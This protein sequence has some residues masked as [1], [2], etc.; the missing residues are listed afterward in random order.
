MAFNILPTGMSFQRL[1]QFPLD[2][3][4]IHNTL[5]EAMDYAKNNPTAYPGQILYVADA[6]SQEEIAANVEPSESLYMVT[7][8]GEL[9]LVVSKK[10]L[11]MNEMVEEVE[12]KVAE[13]QGNLDGA[14][15]EIN[16]AMDEMQKIADEVH[17][18]LDEAMQKQAEE[19]QAKLEEMQKVADEVHAELNENREQLKQDLQEQIAN[20]HEAMRKEAEE[21]HAEIE[22]A[23]ADMQ[24]EA[25]AKH[26][27]MQKAAE[28]K[29]AEMEAKMEA[30]HKAMKEESD[31]KHAE[32]EQVIAD[33]KAESEAKHVEMEEEAKAKHEEM[34]AEADAEHKAVRELIDIQKPFM[35]D[36]AA[37]PTSKF[38]FACGNPITVEPNKGQKYDVEKPE[39][40]V[41][42]VYRWAEG[43]EAIVVE[44]EEAAKV[45]VVGGHGH[46][47]V[48]VKR[49][50]P[51]TNILARDV[52]IKGIVG[53]SYFEG[54]VGH[55]NI[56]AENCE[57]VSVMGAGWCGASIDGQWTRMNIVDDINMKLT[58]CKVS[59]TLFGGAQGNGVA[60]DIHMELNNCQIGWLTAGGANGMTRNAE[61]VM[62]GGTVTV[63]QSTNR[64]VV[65]KAKLVL[66]DG[67]INSLYFG[68][69]TE[70]TTVDGI[71][72]DGHIELNGGVVKSFNFGT[73]NGI[74][75][76]AEDIKGS[77]RECV[78]NDGDVSMLEQSKHMFFGGDDKNV[79]CDN[80]DE[81]K[82]LE[83]KVRVDV[84]EVK[85]VVPVG[86]QR[87]VIAVPEEE[88]IEEI[89]YMG[90]GCVDYK[91][92]FEEE[93]IEGHKVMTYIFAVPCSAKMTFKI[94]LK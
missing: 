78:V 37:Y 75:M 12:N 7:A 32:I 11:D 41:A 5:A 34:K 24:A 90:Q 31:A 17:A 15:D 2:S 56:E 58:N 81:V 23:M 42:F 60:D 25:D 22:Q 46:D 77:I 53:G 79:P 88:E 71:I 57:F 48:K 64:G 8:S 16:N 66:N 87:V 94:I 63:A 67:V 19:N 26:E 70:D 83:G 61:V 65:H 50:I 52:K 14:V 39:D 76:V 47:K 29:H 20:E 54:M 10:D 6:R 3:T 1:G 82:A 91:D 28:D 73:N 80:L 13:L 35:A 89:Q 69:E 72:E 74:E 55:A 45:Y 92:M 4:A 93:V 18:D 62:N 36:L 44:K 59:S 51:Q 68:G 27:E 84:K 86:S 33:F 21:K 38:L 49:P 9:K 40:A 30:D 43:F 85:F